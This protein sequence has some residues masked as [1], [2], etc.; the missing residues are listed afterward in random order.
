MT[1]KKIRSDRSTPVGSRNKRRCSICGK[2]MTAPHKALS[3]EGK[4]LCD[5]CYRDCFFDDVDSHRDRTLDRCA[6]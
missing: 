2:R 3:I 5:A 1:T 6:I 4:G